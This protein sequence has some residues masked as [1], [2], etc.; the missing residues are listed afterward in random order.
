MTGQQKAAV[1]AI[2]VGAIIAILKVFGIDIPYAPV[3]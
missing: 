2:V 3:V 1:A